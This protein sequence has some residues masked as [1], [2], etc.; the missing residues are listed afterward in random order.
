MCT[1]LCEACCSLLCQHHHNHHH[2]VNGDKRFF[3]DTSCMCVSHVDALEN[4]ICHQ[5][6]C[7]TLDEQ[8]T[9]L[10]F[11]WQSFS[12]P[13]LITVLSRIWFMLAPHSVT[14]Y[15]LFSLINFKLQRLVYPVNKLFSF[16]STFGWFLAWLLSINTISGCRCC[17]LC[18]LVISQIGNDHPV[19]T[20]IKAPG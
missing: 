7:R 19:S 2:R 16:F 3:E 1:L 20:F 18:V 14:R 12:P 8:Q 11:E 13:S 5:P 10:M 9:N 15:P 4:Q 6:G 17:T